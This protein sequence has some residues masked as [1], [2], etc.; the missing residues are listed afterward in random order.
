MKYIKAEN[1]VF[2]LVILTFLLFFGVGIFSANGSQG[3]GGIVPCGRYIGTAEE[4]KPCTLCHLIIGIYR[5]IDYGRKI[6][7]FVAI[8]TLV[9]G[10]IIYILSAGN[11]NMINLAKSVIWKSLAGFAIILGAW[12]IINYAMFLISTKT[13]L[14]VGA[15]KWNEFSCRTDSTTSIAVAPPSNKKEECGKIAGIKSACYKQCPSH[16]NKYSAECPSS[17]EECCQFQ[18]GPGDACGPGLGGICFVCEGA[19]VFNACPDP[20]GRLIGGT[21]C[22][23]EKICC[24][25]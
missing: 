24:G 5:I 9:I 22:P 4:Q 10:G 1:K 2:F 6:L 25:L 23:D 8:T 16:T 17:G 12:V 7:T 13:D 18:S 15:T 3:S 20:Y 14:G 19:C 11:Q 21:D